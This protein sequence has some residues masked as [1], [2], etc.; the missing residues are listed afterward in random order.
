MVT[1]A[2]EA[3]ATEP[4]PATDERTSQD[5]AAWI[6]ALDEPAEPAGI[7]PRAIPTGEPAMDEPVA[8]VDE[9]VAVVDEPMVDEPAAVADGPMVDEPLVIEPAADEPVVDVAPVAGGIGEAESRP[10][11]SLRRRPARSRAVGSDDLAVP[12]T[13]DIPVYGA[14]RLRHKPP[15]ARHRRRAAASDTVA[16][17]PAGAGAPSAPSIDDLPELVV[18]GSTAAGGSP[19]GR[20][21]TQRLSLDPRRPAGLARI[22]ALALTGVSVAA[23]LYATVQPGDDGLTATSETTVV[24][25]GTPELDPAQF[26]HSGTMPDD[27]L[28]AAARLAGPPRAYGSTNGKRNRYRSGA[29]GACGARRMARPCPRP[30]CPSPPTSSRSGP[31]PTTWSSARA[32]SCSRC[33]RRATTRRFA[34]RS[35]GMASQSCRA[36]ASRW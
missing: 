33:A 32:G 26:E 4:E 25:N 17:T 8:V 23:L 31:T 5:V 1:G 20:P 30:P 22:G 36:R 18:S 10:A 19:G 12:S 27:A 35:A 6:A 29:R 11:P 34:G 7:W 28:S 24:H 3:P 16:E 15:V 2:D 13:R 14:A 9:P 21:L